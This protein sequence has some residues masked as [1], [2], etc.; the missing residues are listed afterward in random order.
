MDKEARINAT[1]MLEKKLGGVKELV[2]IAIARSETQ[3]KEIM[4]QIGFREI[5][6]EKL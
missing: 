5:G 1:D 6:V 3:R 4:D 2:G